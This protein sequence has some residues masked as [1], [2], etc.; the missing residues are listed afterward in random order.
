MKN[1][2]KFNFPKKEPKTL[3]CNN[4]HFYNSYQTISIINLPEILIFTLNRDNSDRIQI[5]PDDI[6]EMYDYLDTQYNEIK[7]KY[8]LFAINYLKNNN[9]E[10][11][12]QIYRNGKWF[13]IDDDND[14]KEI[15]NPKGSIHSIGLF[16]GRI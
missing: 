11:K 15:G 5:E 16:Y 7:G 9:L 12:C 10:Y 2:L 14:P 3:K 13:E 6:I 8:K 1:I 4:G